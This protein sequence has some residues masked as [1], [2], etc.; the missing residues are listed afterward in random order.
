[1][2]QTQL[3]IREMTLDDA[4]CV[5]RLKDQVGWN[6]TAD[7]IRRLIEYEPE[8]CF[9]AEVDSVPVGTVSTTSYGTRLAWIGMMLVLP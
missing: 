4:D 8:G 3:H 9:M 6:Q 7:D 5:T 1:M 2:P